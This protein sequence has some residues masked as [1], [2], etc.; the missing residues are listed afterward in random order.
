M[1]TAA[2]D[3]VDSCRESTESRNLSTTNVNLSDVCYLKFVC[4][5]TGQ[6]H[7]ECK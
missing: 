2:Y 6:P 3:A 7:N 4:A 5:R 1:K